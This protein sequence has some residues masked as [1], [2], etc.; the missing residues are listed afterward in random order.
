VVA[1]GI[2][3]A[4]GEPASAARRTFGDHAVHEAC[5]AIVADARRSGLEAHYVMYH[6]PRPVQTACAIAGDR[7]AG[8]LVLGADARAL[9]WVRH[10]LAVRSI[11]RRAPCLVWVG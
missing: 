5:R 9:G 8:L 11:R 2:P 7:E 3:L 4:A 1:N 6:H 10:A